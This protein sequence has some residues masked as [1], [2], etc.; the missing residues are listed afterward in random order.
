ML[1]NFI[2]VGL[3]GAI[4]AVAR[5]ACILVAGKTDFPAATLI[6]NITG[7][8]LIGMLL[9]WEFGNSA[10]GNQWKLLLGTGICGGFTTFSAFTAENFQ[11]VR[12]G[13]FLPMLLYVAVSVIGGLLATWFGF[14]LVN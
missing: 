10:S 12:E 13:G 3:G 5:Y 14:R 11:L 8:F 7:S 9:G 4:G 6:V 2:L 1:K